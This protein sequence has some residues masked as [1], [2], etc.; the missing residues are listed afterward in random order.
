MRIA[1]LLETAKAAG[2]DAALI[3]TSENVAYYSR[4][5][6]TSSQLLIT[7]D[8][9]AHTV[10]LD[11]HYVIQPN[12]VWWDRNEYLKT[13]GGRPVADGFQYSSDVNPVW[14]TNEQLAALLRQE[15]I[16]L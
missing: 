11:D 16:E 12:D 4:F 10:E 13:T 1:K 9:A 8:D 2:A 14:M 5:S 15:P 6:G 3:T 7:P